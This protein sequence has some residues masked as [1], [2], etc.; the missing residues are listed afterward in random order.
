MSKRTDRLKKV[1]QLQGKLAAFHKTRRHGL[2]AEAERA[3]AEAKALLESFAAPG[4]PALLF[5][6]T[7]HRRI[8][9]AGRTKAERLAAAEREAERLR[10]A[11]QREKITRG[12]HAAARRADERASQE[13]EILDIVER[14]A[15]RKDHV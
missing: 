4:S 15:L 13:Q 7:Y 6:E 12:H 8:V 14:M 3:D 2:L 5:P 9:Q 1:M 10:Q 11:R